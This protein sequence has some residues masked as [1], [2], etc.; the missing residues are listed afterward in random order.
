[1]LNCSDA[2]SAAIFRVYDIEFGYNDITSDGATAID[3]TSKFNATAAE[4]TTATFTPT[5]GTATAITDKAAFTPTENGVLTVTIK[6]AGYK[7]IT[8]TLN[9]TVST[10]A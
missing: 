7:A 6:K 5:G 1:M 9:V 2:T 10:G 8:Y 4:M 3:L